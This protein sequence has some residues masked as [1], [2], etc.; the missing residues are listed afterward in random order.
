VEI[1]EQAEMHNQTRKSIIE[2]CRAISEN[3]VGISNDFDAK[4]HLLTLIV[5]KIE[6][7]KDHIKMHTII[8]NLSDNGDIDNNCHIL[9][10]PSSQHYLTIFMHRCLSRDKGQFADLTKAASFRYRIETK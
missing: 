10:I 8:P 9:S 7:F 5:E 4:R 3:L 2:Y 6:I 1:Q